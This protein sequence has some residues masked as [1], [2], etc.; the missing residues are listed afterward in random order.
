MS[1]IMGTG[2]WQ[3][4]YIFESYLCQLSGYG[5]IDHRVL[6]VTSQCIWILCAC[7]IGEWEYYY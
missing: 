7:I 2:Q 1:W 6:Q 4:T 3:V 5:G